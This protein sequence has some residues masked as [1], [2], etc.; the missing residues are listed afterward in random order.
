MTKKRRSSKKKYKNEKLMV[1]LTVIGALVA[2]YYVITGLISVNA[3]FRFNPA[4]GVIEG[5]FMYI[6]GLIIVILT[7][8]CALRP[9]DPIPFHW[10]V[11]IIFAILIVIFGGGLIACLLLVIA[12]LIGLIEDIQ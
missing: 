6:I 2:L 12:G 10:L 4:I 1:F 8:L 5:I 11:L 3:A 9:D 7:L